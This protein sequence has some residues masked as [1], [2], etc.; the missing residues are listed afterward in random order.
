MPANMTINSDKMSQNDFVDDLKHFSRLFIC[1]RT[2]CA[3][4]DGTLLGL[5]NDLFLQQFQNTT[6]NMFII[7]YLSIEINDLKQLL[8]KKTSN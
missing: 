8:N 3:C 4:S 6:D 7:I 2:L 1:T 5:Y